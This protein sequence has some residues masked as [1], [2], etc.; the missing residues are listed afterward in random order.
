M[1]LNFPEKFTETSVF[2]NEIGNL[3]GLGHLYRAES[4]LPSGIPRWGFLSSA[5]LNPC[6]VA[7]RD[8]AALTQ[9]PPFTKSVVTAEGTAV[10]FWHYY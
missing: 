8:V 7:S 1:I 3:N 2:Q 6:P 4:H 5:L 10:S 9:N